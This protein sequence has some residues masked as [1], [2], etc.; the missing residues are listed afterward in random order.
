MDAMMNAVMA[1]MDRLAAM[2]FQGSAG[3]PMT[4][5]MPSGPGEVFISTFSSGGHGSCSQTVTYRSDGTGQPKVDVRQSGD[6][7]GALAAP[8][9]HPVP[10][11]LPEL[12]PDTVAPAAEPG[13]RVYKIDYRRPVTVKPV[14]HG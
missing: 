6:A 11:A 4:V 8:G 1:R 2:P 14:L 10:A 12:Q 5:D 3:G 13:Q 7:C 9:G